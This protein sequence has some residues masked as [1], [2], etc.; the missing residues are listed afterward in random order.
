[1]GRFVALA[2]VAG[3]A[4]LVVDL[5]RRRAIGPV[6]TGRAPGWGL[7]VAIL[8][9]AAIG[10][11][12]VALLR[13]RTPPATSA[14]TTPAAPDIRR[15]V[16]GWGLGGIAGAALISLGVTLWALGFL[17]LPWATVGCDTVPLTVNHFILGAC[18]GLDAGDVLGYLPQPWPPTAFDATFASPALGLYELLAG[19]GVLVLGAIWRGAWRM[20]LS[21]AARVW[22][23]VWLGASSLA[24]AITMRGV[25]VVLAVRPRVSSSA[26]TAV[27]RADMGLLVCVLG[28]VIG[29]LGLALLDLALRRAVAPRRAMRARSAQS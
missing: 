6:E 21:S 10:F 28:L 18:A 3:V 15:A 11:A 19:G 16:G 27:W 25:S 24:A 4:A 1:M 7:L 2:M 9:L 8:A 17:A 13:E 29:W 20:R 5:S 22:V 23:A 14:T 26:I 12:A